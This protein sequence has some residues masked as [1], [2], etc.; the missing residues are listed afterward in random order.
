[1]T[2]SVGES[3]ALRVSISNEHSGVFKKDQSDSAH[4]ALNDELMVRVAIYGEKAD[5]E[6]GEEISGQGKSSAEFLVILGG[7]LL[8]FDVD[9]NGSRREHR[10]AHRLRVG[11]DVHRFADIHLAR[12]IP[13]EVGWFQET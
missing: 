13:R 2:Q 9:N 12:A 11:R 3:S 10:V 1:M 4:P 8:V 5:L 7:E 6:A